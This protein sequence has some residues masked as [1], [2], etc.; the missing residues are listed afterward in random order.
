MAMFPIAHPGSGH[1]S[2]M[3]M[4]STKPIGS[5][6]ESRSCPMSQLG[7]VTDPSPEFTAVEILD[8][9]LLLYLK[10]KPSLLSVSSPEHMEYA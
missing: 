7:L 8:R 10:A 4:A 6:C 1:V 5:A 9:R 3:V 2:P